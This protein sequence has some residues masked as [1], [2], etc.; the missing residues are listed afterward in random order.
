VF[1]PQGAFEGDER[2]VDEVHDD[3]LGGDE[4]AIELAQGHR[5]RAPGAGLGLV[6]A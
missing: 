1:D 2:G 3:D 5:F 4:Q 6:G